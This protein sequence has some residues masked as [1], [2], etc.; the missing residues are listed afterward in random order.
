VE[1]PQYRIRLKVVRYLYTRCLLPVFNDAQCHVPA[2]ECC[3]CYLSCYLFYLFTVSNSGLLFFHVGQL[4]CKAVFALGLNNIGHQRSPKK[5][6]FF[7]GGGFLEEAY[8]PRNDFELIP[9]VE[10][11][12]R[13]LVEGSFGS[14]F[15]RSVIIA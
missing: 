15:P 7:W 9:S 6:I 12:T 5:K 4:S 11:K 3:Q 10:M 2:T 13:N 14:E 8:R 1:C